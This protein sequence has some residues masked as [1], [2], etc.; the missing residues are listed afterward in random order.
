MTTDVSS[1]TL[2]NLLEGAGFL[3]TGASSNP[4]TMEKKAS[5]AQAPAAV[6]SKVAMD[7]EEH[8]TKQANE[9]IPA[10]T[11]SQQGQN[12]AHQVLALIKRANDESLNPTV[13]G[14]NVTNETSNIA[15]MSTAGQQLQPNQGNPNQV[16]QMTLAQALQSGAVHPDQLDLNVVQ[17]GVDEGNGQM[18]LT[19]MAG[20]YNL[21]AQGP[22]V[23]ADNI[24]KVAAVATLIDNGVDFDSAVAMVKQA[25][26][27]ILAEQDEMMKRAA[28]NDL[29]G[30]GY[31]VETA[32]AL[33]KQASD[34]D[35]E[36]MVK[37]AAVEELMSQG[38]D[39]V[40]AVELIK[41]ASAAGDAAKKVI[42]QG[43]D[44]ASQAGQTGKQM[45]GDAGNFLSRGLDQVMNPTR[46]IQDYKTV[47][48]AA[49]AGQ[50]AV[51]PSWLQRKLFGITPQEAVGPATA[52][53][54][55]LAGLGAIA[56]GLTVAGAGLGTVG[57]GAYG[58]NRA[59][60]KEATVHAALAQ[61]YTVEQALALL[62]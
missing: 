58:V 48:D 21:N 8:L 61:G 57:L 23:N 27:S 60:S 33:V 7:L 5:Q 24:E 47:R 40:T 42:Q 3:E 43:K 52:G 22:A 15:A 11:P 12:L 36:E 13:I 2:D 41:Q 6:T 9:V 56:P 38:Y 10:M 17:P 34:R 1:L 4:S 32:V 62:G 39:V 46:T 20:N 30:K 18:P 28:V 55:R 49:L 35:Y 31:D 26:E 53:Q 54:A 29:I 50:E 14:N 45:A 19:D 16:L 37:R 59:M 25:E 51:N 44:M